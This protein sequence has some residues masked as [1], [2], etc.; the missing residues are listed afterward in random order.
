M[1]VADKLSIYLFFIYFFSIYYSDYKFRAL[2]LYMQ[3]YVLFMWLCAQN[4][5]K[6]LMFPCDLIHN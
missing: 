2:F 4:D 3:Q 6:F 5:Y 1:Y